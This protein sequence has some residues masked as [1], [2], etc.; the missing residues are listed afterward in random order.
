MS[1]VMIIG[2]GIS[3]LSA[4][5]YLSKAGIRPTLIESA[6][7]GGVIKTE[8]VHGNLLEGGPDSFMAAKPAAMELIREVGLGD[9][10][11]NSNDHLRKT[12]ILKK[13]K[14]VA[15]PDGLMMMVPTK[16]LPL[17]TT[18]LLSWGCKIRMGLE[19]L[20]RPAGKREDRSVADFLIDHYGQEA[21]DYLAEPLLAGVYGGDPREMSVNSVLTRF[22]E[23]E[24]KYGSLSR[25]VLAAP[26]PPGSGSG[27]SLFR[28]LK[29]GLGSLVDKLVPAA[30]HIQGTAEAFLQ[31]SS[32]LRVRVNG[33]WLDADSVIVATPAYS[34]GDLLRPMAGRLADLLSKI[35]YND[36]TTLSL[37][38]KKNAFA[39]PAQGFGFLVPKKERGY[40]AACTWVNNKFSGRAAADTGLLRCFLGKEGMAQTDE[41]LVSIAREELSR[42]MGLKAEPYFY[43]V[44]R[45]PA[46]MPQYI[47]GHQARMEEIDALA[48]G[49]PG[50]SLVGNG[51]RGLGIPDCIQGGKAVAAKIVG[52]PVAAGA[53]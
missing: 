38:Y 12:Y 27:G 32:G 17:I 1:K 6:R 53:R 37:G 22:V 18:P 34:A 46:S 29:N 7:L 52:A 42:I 25:G 40:M 5:Y 16:I 13:G 44:S 26:K 8:R 48:A 47:V 23:I 3:G 30:D 49:I 28:T 14:P 15:M 39:Y 9:D 24:A 33:N 31:D 21:L 45:W 19:M 51:Y 36:S 35:P 2:G 20:R 50:L 11:I 41:A 10:V 43:S 4:A